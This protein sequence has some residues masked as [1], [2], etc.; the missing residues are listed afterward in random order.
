[1]TALEIRKG[2]LDKVEADKIVE[3]FDGRRPPS[4]ELLLEYVGLTEA[5]F[6]EIVLKTVVSPHSPDFGAIKE[7]SKIHDF[8]RWYRERP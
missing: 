6:N 4:L 3:E 1:M 7:A 2:E 5:E 8:D